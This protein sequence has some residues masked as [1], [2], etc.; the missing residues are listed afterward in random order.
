MKSAPLL[1]S[2]C[3]ALLLYACKDPTSPQAGPTWYG[4]AQ[5]SCGPA[6]GL[7]VSLSLDTTSYSGCADTTHPGAYGIV[8]DLGDVDSLKAGKVVAW[9]LETLCG[10]PVRAAA[11][12]ACGESTEYRLDVERVDGDKVFGTF[13]IRNIS[14][15]RDTVIR[16]GPATL[17]K[18]HARPLCG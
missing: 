14:A 10:N 18:C 9:A 16:Q 7:T 11:K 8:S 13:R 12:T 15:A 1:A 6:D 5:N 4:L 17:A 3:V 2:G